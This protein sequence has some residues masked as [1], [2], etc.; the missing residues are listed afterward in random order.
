MIDEPC[1]TCGGI[2]EVLY[3][4]PAPYS[5]TGVNDGPWSHA[6]APCL[7]TGVRH[8]R[9]TMLITRFSSEGADDPNRRSDIQAIRVSLPARRLADVDDVLRVAVDACLEGREAEVGRP[10]A[11]V[12]GRELAQQVLRHLLDGAHAVAIDVGAS[13]FVQSESGDTVVELEGIKTALK[14]GDTLTV[15]TTTTI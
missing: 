4:A 7:G 2:G 13:F 10:L 5:V 3:N 12:L 9:A 1:V 15:T 6:C 14:N 8:V 11:D